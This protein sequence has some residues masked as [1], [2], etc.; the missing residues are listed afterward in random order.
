MMYMKENIK[1]LI[2]LDNIHRDLYDFNKIRENLQCSYFRTDIKKSIERTSPEDFYLKTVNT[3]KECREKKDIICIM[4]NSW[5]DLEIN[6]KIIDNILHI[7]DE[8]VI[9]YNDD[10]KEYR[11]K[12]NLENRIRNKVKL[13]YKDHEYDYTYKIINH[14]E[15]FYRK[16]L[17]YFVY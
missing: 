14:I 10:S 9:I 15:Y 16:S 2:I 17:G 1:I 8:C 12:L 4:E 5:F 11:D 6:E 3:I 13:L 7:F